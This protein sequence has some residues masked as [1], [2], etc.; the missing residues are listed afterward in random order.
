MNR[1]PQQ[2]FTLIELIV[3]IGIVGVLAA[4][5]LPMYRDYTKRSKMSEV[6]LA[7]ADCRLAI[8]EAYQNGVRATGV[9]N[10]WGCEASEPTRYVAALNTDEAG[11]IIVTARGFGDSSI[12]G[13]TIEL[14]PITA[15]G[16]PITAY[17]SGTVIRGWK[18]VPST[19]NGIL[20]AYLPGSCRG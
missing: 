4:V 1:L 9:A 5:A 3:C 7:A 8:S 16:A 18:C 15:T 19:T 2:G 17:A 11:K 20:P 13:R 14:I 12:D 6:V 10:D